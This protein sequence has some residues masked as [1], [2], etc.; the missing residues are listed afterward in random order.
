VA[1]FLDGMDPPLKLSYGIRAQFAGQKKVLDAIR[2]HTE[3]FLGCVS[4]PSS[5]LL[6]ANL[7]LPSGT[8][9]A[10]P[11]TGYGNRYLMDVLLEWIRHTPPIM[12][13]NASKEGH[14]LL[15]MTIRAVGAF[16]SGSY[17]LATAMLQA[18]AKPGS[19]KFDDM[20]CHQQSPQR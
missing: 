15:D 18:G 7:N 1:P 10:D 12:D 5:L 8:A 11:Q 16:N 13:L 4:D 14:S 9:L 19:P 17:D 20:S 6:T 3:V 2:H